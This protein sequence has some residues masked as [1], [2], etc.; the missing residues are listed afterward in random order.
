LAITKP[1]LTNFFFFHDGIL[2]ITKPFLTNFF[3]FSRWNSGY[4]K[5]FS[6]EL[7]LFSRWNSRVTR[8]GGRLFSYIY[9]KEYLHR[10]QLVKNLASSFRA[11]FARK[12]VRSF[13]F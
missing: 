3:F 10:I 4:H 9:H 7:F 5:A 13:L 1:F 8:F 12:R 6:Y 2:A 11:P